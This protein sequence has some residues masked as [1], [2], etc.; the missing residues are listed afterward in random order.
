[1]ALSWAAVLA[2]GRGRLWSRLPRLVAGRWPLVFVLALCCLRVRPRWPPVA[3]DGR[4]WSSF[5][6]CLVAGLASPFGC[7]PSASPGPFGLL[8]SALAAPF[9]PLPLALPALLGLFAFGVGCIVW[10]LAF[11]V[12]CVGWCLWLRVGFLASSLLATS[13][14]GGRLSF[15]LVSD[16]GLGPGRS[17]H[18][19]GSFQSVSIAACCRRWVTLRRRR[20]PFHLHR[21]SDPSQAAIGFPSPVR[22]VWS[23]LPGDRRSFSCVVWSFTGGDRWSFSYVPTDPWVAVVGGPSAL[24][25][26]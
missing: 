18:R 1:L 19:L 6:P 7:L 14:S 26:V 13:P 15:A 25:R 24:A 3:T 23:S 9:G 11:G 20:S 8:P 4:D 12:A 5:S 10:A 22:V 17:L 2:G 21:S 16:F